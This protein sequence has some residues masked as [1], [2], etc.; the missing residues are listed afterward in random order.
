MSEKNNIRLIL[1]YDGSQYHGWQRQIG[2]PTVQQVL[3]DKIKIMTGES[4]R[5]IASGRTDSGVH[6][7]HQVCNFATHSKIDPG[8][9]KKGLNSLLPDDIFIKETTYAPQA[10]HARYD[11][12]SKIYEYRILNQYEPDTFLRFYIWHIRMRLDLAEMAKCVSLLLGEHDFSSFRSSGSGNINPV[13][14]MMRAEIHDCEEGRLYFS[15][16]ADGF[17]RHMVRNIVGTII[18]VGLGKIGFHEFEGIFHAKDRRAAGVKAPPQGL[19]LKMVN[20]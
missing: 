14:K 4:V 9:M 13:R 8:S 5:L 17:L 7:L 3:E 18:D 12:K 6:A 2:S 11:A 1:E 19:F 20:Y 16:E 15:F 10:F